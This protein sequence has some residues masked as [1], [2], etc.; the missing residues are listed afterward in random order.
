MIFFDKKKKQQ[1]NIDGYKVVYNNE[2]GCKD[3]KFENIM[4][5]VSATITD[6]FGNELYQNFST[7]NDACYAV[8]DLAN[9]G[10]DAI[11]GPAGPKKNYYTGKFEK[12]IDDEYGVYIVTKF[13]KIK[14]LTKKKD[15]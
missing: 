2:M 12:N 6:E 4:E 3:K 9:K 7:Y 10:I 8:C 5:L 13:E 11:I 14:S 1:E 15:V